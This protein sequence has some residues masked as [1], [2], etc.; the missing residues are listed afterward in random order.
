MKAQVSTEL[1]V[2]YA[3]VLLVFTLVLLSSY[4]KQISSEEIKD[5]LDIR[6]E[7]LKISNIISSVYLGGNGTTATIRLRNYLTLPGDGTIVLKSEKH[8]EETKVNT[9]IVASEAGET[10]Q[11]FYDNMTDKIEPEWYKTCFVDIGGAAGCQQWQADG[12]TEATWNSI[13]WNISDL[14]KN[15]TVNQGYYQTVYIED[16]HIM[17]F[18]NY[19]GIDY[20]EILENWTSKGN[21][22]VLSEHVRCREKAT[23]SYEPTSYQCNPPTDNS[24]VWS[25]MGIK[26]HQTGLK[27]WTE[28]VNE[29]V[30]FGLSVGDQFKIEEANWIENVN[31]SNMYVIGR[32]QGEN[33]EVDI[34]YWEIGQGRVY[35]FA[36]FQITDDLPKSLDQEE[37]TE[38]LATVIEYAYNILHFDA[39]SEICITPVQTASYN[40]LYGMI[41]F[42]NDNGRILTDVIGDV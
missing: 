23:G 10:L 35:Y 29:S 4:N 20:F 36:D 31:N 37:Y 6:E 34:A 1:I 16:P 25:F 15:L 28:I 12:M 38:V 39:K 32:Y 5:V 42:E 8:M 26:I 3:F 21:I 7:C 13:P 19:S 40:N 33:G 22:L 11:S 9:A 2:I 24:D 27:K 18:A 17:F 41:R 30:E 14:M